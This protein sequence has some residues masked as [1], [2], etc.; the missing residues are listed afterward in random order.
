MESLSRS[1]FSRLSAGTGVIFS[2]CNACD[3]PVAVSRWEIELEKAE[4][5]HACN[6]ETLDLWTIFIGEVNRRE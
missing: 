3:V 6:P 4:R 5:E 1:A 2:A